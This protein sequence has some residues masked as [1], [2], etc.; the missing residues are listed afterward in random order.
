M[1]E[2]ITKKILV[3]LI[4]SSKENTQVNINKEASVSYLLKQLK[5]Q[6]QLFSTDESSIIANILEKLSQ[7]KSIKFQILYKRLMSLNS[8][9]NK[10]PLI[11]Y[12]LSIL[13]NE[14]RNEGN[15]NNIGS[16]FSLINNNLSSE[17]NNMYN[18][19]MDKFNKIKYGET[20]YLEDNNL[21]TVQDGIN[22]LQNNI[23]L[24][25]QN[26]KEIKL[27]VNKYLYSQIITERDLIDD[28]IYVFQGTDGK[29]INY[30]TIKN[31]YQLNTNIPFNENVYDIVG[32]ISELGWLYRKTTNM[33]EYL[34]SKDSQSLI[35]QSFIFSVE[36][37]LVQHY[38]LIRLIKLSNSNEDDQFT[39]KRLLLACVIPLEK[40][41]WLSIACDSVYCTILF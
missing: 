17:I 23:V 26:E 24:K 20:D 38:K 18:N 1:S 29:F 28:L 9:L 36:N 22:F 35:L 14:D 5:A 2:E 15:E 41:R 27:V 31:C 21:N 8:K 34:K 11:L 12:F 4:Q 37:E 25:K 3:N 19:Q 32:Q 40:M 7:E 33:I 16:V 30:S 10:R 39:L 6:R 13:A